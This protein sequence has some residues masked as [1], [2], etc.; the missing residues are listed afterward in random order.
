MKREHYLQRMLSGGLLP[1]LLAGVML[2]S[3]TQEELPQDGGAPLT[4]GAYPLQ[5]SA[6]V[7]DAVP[8]RAGGKNSWTGGEEI[9]VAVG[10]NTYKYRIAD[11]QGKME[12]ADTQ[13][14]FY[15]QSTAQTEDITA[16]YPY[17]MTDA[18][19][20]PIDKVDISDQS[21]GYEK[22]DFLRAETKDVKYNSGTVSL[23]FYHRMAKVKYT[24]VKHES[25]TDAE[26]K[27]ATVRIYGF[28]EATFGEGALSGVGNGWITPYKE[29]TNATEGEAVVVPQFINEKGENNPFIKVTVN[30]N[31]YFYTPEDDEANLLAGKVYTYHITVKKD[32]IDV[33]AV[34]G[35]EWG[36]NGEQEITSK[37]VKQT[38]TATELK[39]GDYF[40]SDGSWSDGGLRKI[41]ADGSMI[42]ANPKPAPEEDKTVVGIVFQTALSR[43]GQA[44]KDALKTKGINEPHGLVMSVKNAGTGLMWSSENNGF[45]EL[46]NCESKEQC[47]ADI[48]G[49]WNYNTVIAYAKGANKLSS[50]PAF[51]AVDKWNAEGS[52][53]KAPENTT[54]WYLPAVGQWYDFF[55]NLGGLPDWGSA[56]VSDDNYYWSK[57]QSESVLSNVNTFSLRSATEITMHS[58]ISGFGGAV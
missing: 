35:G 18:K 41:Y 10:G 31:D 50:Y 6:Y 13:K 43:I 1:L 37:E 24:L 26:L 51:E 25:T 52:E 22:F 17:G 23:D 54:G 42:V 57:Q 55:H 32:G 36:S 19:G 40:Y 48:S 29:G 5:V 34:T 9:A 16:W 11:T 20:K 21:K 12:Y 14:Q 45:G 30:G 33:T 46:E 39:I 3:C 7:V 38:F 47:N 15:W 53:H 44:E 28:T 58:D 8:T 4:D 27:D 2:A 49:L 56:S